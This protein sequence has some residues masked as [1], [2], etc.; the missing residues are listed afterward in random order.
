MSRRN[1]TNN[2]NNY[3]NFLKSLDNSLKKENLLEENNS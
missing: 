1:N 3:N 2:I